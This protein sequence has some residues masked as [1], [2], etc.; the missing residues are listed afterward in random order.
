MIIPRSL[1]PASVPEQIILEFSMP[2]LLQFLQG[3]GWCVRPDQHSL[4]PQIIASLPDVECIIRF[5]TLA[6]SGT[7]WSD[8]TLSAPFSLTAKSRPSLV[9]C[10]TAKTVSDV[11]T[12]LTN[13]CS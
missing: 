9:L 12:G 6:R 5:G 7:G 10:G 3:E 2:T 4:F 13:H 11:S 8:F 1:A